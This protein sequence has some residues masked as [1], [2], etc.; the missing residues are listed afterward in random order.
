M[1]TKKI[2]AIDIGTNSF[3]IIVAELCE[4]GK[5]NVIRDE[6]EFIRLDDKHISNNKIDR[7]VEVIKHFK[8]IAEDLRAD[9]SAVA[10]SGVREAENADEF[11]ST[12]K[13]KT[14]VN[15]K[16]ISGLE[17]ARLI[18]LGA[19]NSIDLKGKTTLCFDIGGGS[20]EF[21]LGNEENIIL[22][23][24][25]KLGAVRLTR[26]YFPDGNVTD[27][28]LTECTKYVDEHLRE[29]ATEIRNNKYDLAIAT[30]G[31]GL[32]VASIIYTKKHKTIPTRKDLNGYIFTKDE[33]QNLAKEILELK[34][35]Q[36]RENIKGLEIARADIIP[37]GI[38]LLRSIIKQFNIEKVTVSEYA[39][40]EGIVYDSNNPTM[41]N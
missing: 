10:T 23:K 14:G 35:I 5:L 7:S 22:A 21:I 26:K 20:S 41:N 17:E 31:T 4:D 8:N 18:F 12:I 24:S 9:I 27:D 3:H 16:L 33:L 15:V 32:A 2:A 6:R 37:A 1:M 40:R 19:T 11:I 13:E 34:T 39:L 30:S 29:T 25:L 28:M 38:I 36:E